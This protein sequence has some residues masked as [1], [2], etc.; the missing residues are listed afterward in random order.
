MVDRAAVGREGDAVGETDAGPQRL[1]GAVRRDP[2]QDLF[3]GLVAQREGADDEPTLGVDRAVVEAHLAA[4]AEQVGAEG[5][6]AVGGDGREPACA[7]DEETAVLGEGDR[8]G[9]LADAPS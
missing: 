7:G 8:A 2:Q 5:D 6:R 3:A 4:L 9:G 1:D